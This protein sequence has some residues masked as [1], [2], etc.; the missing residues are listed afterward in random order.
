MNRLSA[1]LVVSIAITCVQSTSFAQE[2][3]EEK[4]TIAAST[5]LDL[6]INQLQS[7]EERLRRIESKFDSAGK[8]ADIQNV[9]PPTECNVELDVTPGQEV[10]PGQI[11]GRI[12]PPRRRQMIS[13]WLQ[14]GTIII[15]K[16]DAFDGNVKRD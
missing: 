7:I 3:S 1:V 14:P 13:P 16:I 6:I 8:L 11:L 2:I 10:L 15:D 5:K 12:E 9:D 4:A